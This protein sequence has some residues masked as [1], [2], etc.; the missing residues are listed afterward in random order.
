[1]FFIVLKA[2]AARSLFA[3]HAFVAVWRVVD[4]KHGDTTYWIMASSIGFLIIEGF[5]SICLR[6]GREMKWFCPSVFLYLCC[7]IPPTWIMELDL[8]YVRSQLT[9]T[10]TNSSGSA[11]AGRREKL[12]Q[13]PGLQFEINLELP[14][15]MWAKLLEQFLLV[16][17]VIGR[18]L[19]PKGGLTRGQLSQLLLVYIGMAA[20]I[21]ELFE[22]FKEDVVN[23]NIELTCAVLALWSWSLMQ[24]TLVLT[25]TKARKPRLGM[26]NT[27]AKDFVASS[28]PTCCQTMKRFFAMDIWAI[29]TTII[30]QDGPFL[31]LR[32]LLIFKFNVI[33][34]LNIFFTCK[35]SLVLILQ[36]YRMSVLTCE[37]RKKKKMKLNLEVPGE[38][39]VG[40]ADKI[41]EKP[42]EWPDYAQT[43]QKP[44]SKRN[45]KRNRQRYSKKKGNS[46][47]G[48]VQ[49]PTL[50]TDEVDNQFQGH[51]G[52][53]VHSELI[54][55]DFPAFKKEFQGSEKCQSQKERHEKFHGLKEHHEQFQSQKDYHGKFQGQKLGA[56]ELQ[57]YNRPF[58]G[59]DIEE[60]E[61]HDSVCV[62]YSQNK[63]APWSNVSFSL[64][65]PPLSQHHPLKLSRRKSD[66]TSDNDSDVRKITKLKEKDEEK[67]L[68]SI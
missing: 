33:S 67:P 21:V 24:F 35:N 50:P 20:D 40:L 56:Q 25:A 30:F 59:H 62:T 31:C 41:V 54:E 4:V 34:Y 1:M 23:T 48:Y 49:V 12:S 9:S 27:S 53:A 45:Q 55:K 29:M 3:I 57:G 2:V 66:S 44:E 47:N 61:S 18:W 68:L 65:K 46:I 43:E 26:D 37:Q 32:L 63:T 36:V 5:V 10:S 42:I 15:E 6:K 14:A 58:L 28:P 52:Y 13:I 19:L 38:T 7:I 11:M 64:S 16:N 39:I 51:E 8:V 60:L 17:L 22:A